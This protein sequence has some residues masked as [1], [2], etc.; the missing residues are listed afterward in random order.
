M[1]NDQRPLTIP[2]LSPGSPQVLVV[3][4]GL[5]SMH[6]LWCLYE[7]FWASQHGK[8]GAVVRVALSRACQMEDVV[9]LHEA[10]CAGLDLSKV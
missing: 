3:D 4:A 10:L 8:G 1:H 2:R 9:T 6:R 7:V 5:L